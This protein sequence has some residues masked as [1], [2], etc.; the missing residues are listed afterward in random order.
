MYRCFIVGEKVGEYISLEFSETEHIVALTSLP[1]Y[2]IEIWN[3]RTDR[4]MVYQPTDLITDDKF[5]RCSY[6]FPL[7]VFQWSPSQPKMDYWEVHFS[8]DT[9][10]LINKSIKMPAGGN[11]L[12]NIFDATFGIDGSLYAISKNGAVWNVCFFCIIIIT[13]NQLSAFILQ[14]IP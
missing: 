12:A 14:S 6:S 5:I 1:Q 7:T 4:L 2:L 13:P 9:A 11:S 10:N 8:L 3:W